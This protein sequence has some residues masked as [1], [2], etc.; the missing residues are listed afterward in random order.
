M[1]DHRGQMWL[2]VARTRRR[3]ALLRA[4]ADL[5]WAALLPPFA[6]WVFVVAEHLGSHE[7]AQRAWLRGALLIVLGLWCLAALGLV[8]RRVWWKRGVPNME[9]TALLLGSGDEDLRDR[10]LNGIQ[11]L[12]AGQENRQAFDPGLIAASLDHVLPRLQA[13]D[14]KRVLPLAPRRKALRM[15]GAAWAFALLLFLLGGEQ[16]R[17]AFQR[18]WQPEREFRGQPLFE[19]LLSAA[20]PDSLHPG[21]VLEGQSV[22]LRVEVR[23]QA[24][25]DEVEVRAVG[26][27]AGSGPGREASW[28]LPLRMGRAVLAGLAPRGSLQLQASALE[29]QLG[30]R[31]R[32]HSGTLDL[33]WLRPP[34]MDSLLVRI[35]PP[36]YTGLPA[37]SLPDGTADFSCP[38]GS[39]VLVEGWLPSETRHAWLERQDQDGLPAGRL[40][41]TLKG[42]GPW[43]AA[44]QA[45]RSLQW[46]VELEDTHGLRLTQPLLQSMTVIPDAPPRLRVLAPM[47]QE[48]RLERDLRLDIALLAEDDYGFG[49]CRM[50]WKVYSANLRS[51]APPPDPA[52]L[53]AIPK[54]WKIQTMPLRPLPGEVMGEAAPQMRRAATE[55]AWDLSTV[56]LLPDDELLFFFEVWDN[57]GWQGPKVLRTP[58]YRF[59]VPGLEELFAEVRQE[60]E[61][62]EAEAEEL[63]TRTK[64]NRERLEE[65]K[66]ELR[67]DQE[68]T[69]EREQKLK[70]VVREQEQIAQRAGELAER[71]ENAQQKMDANQLVSEELRQKLG[72]LKQLL[73]QV[74]SPELLE[75][76]RKA[77]EAA[78]QQ[79]PP[80]AQQPQAPRDMDEVLRQME[81]QLDRFLAVLEQMKLEQRLEE[82]ARRAEQLL[83]K[84]RQVKEDLAKG[85]DP[86]RKSADEAARKQEAEALRQDMDGLEKELGKESSFPKSQLDEAR[87]QMDQKR[88]AP[89]LGDMQQQMDQGASPSSQEQEEMDQ[90]LSQL[91]ESLQQALQQSKQQAMADLSREIERICQELLVISLRQEELG[92]SFKGL[93]SRSAQLPRLAEQTEENRLGVKAATQGVF[94][95]TRKSLHIPAGALSELGVASHN[96][97]EM[98]AGFHERQL[99]RLSTLS[100]DA[101]GRV[102]ATILMLKEAERNMKKSSSSSGFQEMM[103]KMAEASA[104]QQCLNGQCNKLMGLKPGQSQKPMSISF[105]EAGKEQGAIREQMESLSEQMGQ[106]GKPRLGDMGQA[107]A[108][109][110]EVEKDLAAQSFTERTQKLQERILSRLLD[111]QRSVRK[112]DEEKKRESRSGQDLRAARPA[113]LELQRANALQQDMLRALQGGY[114]PEMQDLIRDYFR[115]LEGTPAAPPTPA[116]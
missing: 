115:A 57:D 7:S 39:R 30:Q 90:D 77:A 48:G 44:Q 13:L 15:S 28:R 100:P 52:T 103:E 106:D 91:A 109:M 93:N 18:L 23:G 22:D 64:E 89:R 19:V 94:E 32:L 35:A 45:T 58:L 54:D 40:E 80:G 107:A 112:Q 38:V 111:A 17:L 85:A 68:M 67:R 116:P 55:L 110:Q 60:E 14:L 53:K 26:L 47:E 108:D 96:L 56:D 36:A 92:S 31:R 87:Q 88:I 4:S 78:M 20:W 65:L 1:T 34:G 84:Q 83:D 49:P 46:T 71:L 59:K 73:D 72:Q 74:M 101:M 102:N 6:V 51:L 33:L 113:P 86:K 114:R 66:Q 3:V 24:L 16:A 27:D 75:K 8:L 98:L 70:Q 5:L 69:W 41:F 105:G 79:P 11:V 25:P 99:G 95:L 12:E 76:L 81:E 82:L 10:L 61:A 21:R 37:Q 63:L 2:L 50:A 43:V 104:R 29:E 42:K 62:I 9:D 97:E